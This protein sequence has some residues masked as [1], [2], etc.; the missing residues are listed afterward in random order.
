MGIRSGSSRVPATNGG[1]S[2]HAK[3]GAQGIAD[4]FAVTDAITAAEDKK[5]VEGKAAAEWAALAASREREEGIG[6]CTSSQ[7]VKEVPVQ[8]IK[9]VEVAN[10]DREVIEEIE[11]V[12]CEVPVGVIQE[13][14][15]EVPV[16][17]LQFE[18]ID[19]NHDG[20]IDRVEYKVALAKGLGAPVSQKDVITKF[21]GVVI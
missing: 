12:Q 9:E 18:D 13:G 15:R 2:A 14:I 21:V 19:T 11:E 3:N 6:K 16:M 8:V 17:W 4:T 7:S 20:L 5:V 10:V 1:P